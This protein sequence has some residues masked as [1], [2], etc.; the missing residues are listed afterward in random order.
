MRKIIISIFLSL[1]IIQTKAAICVNASQY[2][3]VFRTNLLTRSLT[4]VFKL[5]FYDSKFTDYSFFSAVNDLD[6]VNKVNQMNQNKC[7]IIL[8]LITSQECLI[9]GSGL[10]KNKIIGISTCALPFI[11]QFKPYIYSFYP[12][13]DNYLNQIIEYLKK[14][15]NIGHVFLIYQS[16]DMF[17]TASYTK[18]KKM[19]PKTTFD[20]SIDSKNYLDTFN[21]RVKDN[22][23]V[24]LVFF[25]YT[26]P[27]IKL[28]I[29]L[30]DK[31]LITKNTRIIASPAWSFN[32]SSLGQVKYLLKQAK[33][34]VAV[35]WWDWSKIKNN[36]F[37]KQYIKFY[38][39]HPSPLE[40]LMYETAMFAV[41]CYRKSWVGNQFSIAKFQYC[42]LE[43][44]H[45]GIDGANYFTKDSVFIHSTRPPKIINIL[46]LI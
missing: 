26:L 11:N 19:Y 32:L 17:S 34:V 15:Q 24:I 44:S 23:P 39:Q 43:T 9:V 20:I 1:F 46:D 14:P 30:S 35:D 12:S 7:Q 25:T 2:N 8:G 4:P 36:I 5:A 13:I 41:D 6:L 42:A 3:K 29:E 38:N 10:E 37:V 27:A 31:H 16:T 21:L 33:E 28:L 40:M 22:K 45:H 18:F